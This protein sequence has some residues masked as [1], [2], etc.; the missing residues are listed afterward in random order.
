MKTDRQTEL[1]NNSNGRI[2]SFV[3]LKAIALILVFMWHSKIPRP[4]MDIGARACEFLFLCSGFLVAWNG[5]RKG[6]NICSYKESLRIVMRKLSLFWPLHF[7]TF[8]FV[9]FL[10]TENPFT[11]Y[12]AVRGVLNLL[13]LQSWG[14][15]RDLYFS[16]NGTTWFLSC[17]MFCYF[18]SPI[19]IRLSKSKRSSGICFAIAFAIRIAIE[20]LSISAQWWNGSMPIHTHPVVRILEFS[21]GAFISAFVSS[22]PLKAEMKKRDRLIFFSALE[23]LTLFIVCWSFKRSGGLWMR[24]EYIACL[25]VLLLVFAFDS[26]IVS[27]LL[28]T[29]PFVLFSLVQMEFYIIHHTVN[30]VWINHPILMPENIYLETFL[31]FVI[32]YTLAILYKRFASEKLTS[33][34]QTVFKNCMR[35]LGVNSLMI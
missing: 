27:R 23:V 20:Y 2:G 28:S 6:E 4:E 15:T 7:I 21:L 29:K 35:V 1:T 34:M 13:L 30:L 10:A 25:C 19:I 11:K 24:Y 5:R 9:F 3:G 26:G 31:C 33:V 8:L 16:F 12:N 18:L 17:L 14:R 32:S 22:V